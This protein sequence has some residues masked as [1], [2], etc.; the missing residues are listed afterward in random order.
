MG[1]K[2]R[3]LGLKNVNFEGISIEF[4]GVKNANFGSVLKGF[5]LKFLGRKKGNLEENLNFFFQ[6]FQ[7]EFGAKKGGN[8][9]K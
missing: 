1:R 9:K 4:F 2:K 6:V 8:G 3:I 7:G 5:K